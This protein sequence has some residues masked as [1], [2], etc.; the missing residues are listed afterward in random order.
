VEPAVIYLRLSID[1][2]GDETGVTRQREDC[3]RL[4]QLRDLEVVCVES[5]N[6][7]SA[8]GRAT[9][10]AFERVL[11]HIA[12]GRVRIVIAWS[13]DRLTRNRRDTLRLIEV[14]QEHKVTLAI[15][16]G[17]DLDM[18]TPGG[19]LMA[20]LFASIA[21][22]EI[23]VKSDRQRR[24]NRQRAEA[25]QPHVARRA[26][27]YEPDGMTIRSAE[28]DVVRAMV[29]QFLTG[30]TFHEIAQR[31]NDSGISSTEG[32]QFTKKVVRDHITSKRNAGIRLYDGQQYDAVWEPI[33]DR[34][35]HRRVLAEL[36]RRTR[37]IST[38]PASRKYLL[39]GLLYCGRCQQTM[40]GHSKT[41]PG[42][43]VARPKYACPNYPHG[44]WCGN[45]TRLARPL[46]HLVKESVFYRLDTPDLAKALMARKSGG[47]EIG[48]L[49][50]R[51]EDLRSKLRSLVDDY[52]DGT[53]TKLEFS[54]A[55]RRV[56]DALAIVEGKLAAVGDAT[57]IAEVI[58]LSSVEAAWHRESEGWR[59]RLLGLVIE[60]VVVEP[61]RR[62]PAFRVDDETFRFDADSIRIEWKA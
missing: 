39:T 13:L 61:S 23:E 9:R 27:G 56:L 26:F 58:A 44:S 16:R 15:V 43:D 7:I 4:A 20:D 49:V 52:A 25:G 8:S 54:R 17:A 62:R 21:R 57:A 2:A 55:K 45:N 28:A 37:T 24:A 32:K 29:E 31:L 36:E 34:E 1:R 22:N 38:R 53:L 19:R 30:W 6:D 12:S 5:D 18:S 50:E 33:V 35:T 14:A 51:Q 40:A 41:D 47:S 59:R 10:P 48:A 11:E 3:E 46:E 60:R 42:S